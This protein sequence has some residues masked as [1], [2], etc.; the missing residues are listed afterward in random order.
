M[1]SIQLGGKLTNEFKTRY[2]NSPQ[3]KAGAFRNNKRIEMNTGFLRIPSILVKQLKGR[4]DRQPIKPLN[5][6]PFNKDEFYAEERTARMIWYGHSVIF[7]RVNQTNILI[8]PMFGSDTT[9]IAPF[10]SSRYS[11]NTLAIIDDL[12]PIDIVLLT[13]DHYDHLDYG[14]IIRLKS[15]VKQFFVPLGLSRHLVAWGID[16][17]IIN[18]FDWWDTSQ[19]NDIQFSFTPTQHFSG[20]WL[21]DRQMSLWGGWAIQSEN[22][23]IW[24]SGDGGYAGHFCEIG[25]RLGPFDFAF[26]ECGQYNDDWRPV[27][28]FPDESVQAA[29][30]AGVRKAMPIHWAGFSLSYHHTWKD[31]A[32]DFLETSIRYGLDYAFPE[33]GRCFSI[34]DEI[35][36]CW[37]RMCE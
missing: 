15:K 13:H 4:A 22:E 25:K 31:P 19:M 35:K 5:I 23:N 34:N 33:L 16:Q 1:R 26:M 14:S 36:D 18:E 3:W 2:I 6:S 20:R 8:D 21:N 9:P 17:N 28:L 11:E 7:I 27:H 24:I 32:E 30:D 12:P 37:W 29:L 10:K